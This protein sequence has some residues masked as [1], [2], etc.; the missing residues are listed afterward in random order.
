MYDGPV[1]PVSRAG[2]SVSI[3]PWPRITTLTTTSSCGTAF[4][5]PGTETQRRKSFLACTAT[6]TCLAGAT[7]AWGKH[8]QL[9]LPELSHCWHHPATIHALLIGPSIIVAV[10]AVSVAFYDAAFHK[11]G[12]GQ[13][14]K[15]SRVRRHRRCLQ[16]RRNF[17][18]TAMDGAAGELSYWDIARGPPQ[19][20]IIKTGSGGCGKCKSCRGNGRSLR[21]SALIPIGNPVPCYTTNIQ[22]SNER[23]AVAVEHSGSRSVLQRCSGLPATKKLQK[24]KS[25]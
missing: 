7:H 24:W 10:Q 9:P 23:K 17:C 12:T 21:H 22:T 16:A 20:R 5:A 18:E 11:R 6:R 4:R 15:W 8:A 1:H 19:S 25:L 2:N 13:I 14:A 3:A